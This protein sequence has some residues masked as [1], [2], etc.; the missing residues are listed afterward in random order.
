ML[1]EHG[2]TE[3]RARWLRSLVL[4]GFLQDGF[5][6]SAETVALACTRAEACEA[7]GNTFL[8]AE[9]LFE[10]GFA[11]TWGGHL[12]QAEQT[13]RRAASFAERVGDLHIQGQ[14]RC[15]LA[16]GARLRGDVAAARLE[17]ERA[18]AVTE[19]ARESVYTGAAHAQLAW[20]EWRNGNLALAEEG[21][22]AALACWGA[23]P[24]WPFRWMALWPLLGVCAARGDLEGAI[25]QA[26]ALLG[27]GGT[28]PG[29][30][31][32]LQELVTPLARAVAAWEAADRAAAADALAQAMTLARERGRL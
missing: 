20:V 22:R 30:L 9:G 5:A 1:A 6:F 25:A 21:G 32:V 16:A 10:Y 15:Y 4:S 31:P 13:L 24:S 12:D 26:R 29:N 7:T 8:S 3:Q 23:T 2:S 11:L 17:A 28:P 19:A 18:L 27:H 14:S